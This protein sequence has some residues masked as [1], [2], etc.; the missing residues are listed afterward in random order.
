MK[1]M[2]EDVPACHY[3]VTFASKMRDGG[4]RQIPADL[5]FGPFALVGAII[6][7]SISCTGMGIYYTGKGV[8]AGGRDIVGLFHTDPNKW[9][10]KALPVVCT[11]DTSASFDAYRAWEKCRKDI[12]KR[13]KALTK[14]NPANKDNE[15]WCG[16]HAPLSSSLNRPEWESRCNP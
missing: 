1:F 12:L 14:L 6:F 11:P 2:G 13:Q 5:F 9:R 16:L 10:M 15:E 8:A 4:L 3:T 7:D